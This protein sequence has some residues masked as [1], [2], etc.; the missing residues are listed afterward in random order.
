MD[1]PEVQRLRRIRQLG[2]ASVAFPGAEHTRFSHAIGSAH[3]M[4]RLI[5]RLRGGERDL[6]PQHRIAKETATEAL[7][8][9]LLHDVGHGPLSHL[10]E[11]ALVG[12]PAHEEWSTR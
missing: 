3:V 8:A 11:D 7:A 1:T 12:A 4:R 6:L 9:A 5:D 2:V 10:F